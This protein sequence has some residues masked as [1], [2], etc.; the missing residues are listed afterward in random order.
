MAITTTSAVDDDKSHLFIDTNQ[1]F[2]TTTT[3]QSIIDDRNEFN[4]LNTQNNDDDGNNSSTSTSSTAL[5]LSRAIWLAFQKENISLDNNDSQM[6]ANE[7]AKTFFEK[8]ANNLINQTIINNQTLSTTK[9]TTTTTT[10]GGEIFQFPILQQQPPSPISSHED[11]YRHLITIIAYSLII[12]ISLCGNS[13]VLK[14]ILTK[15]KLQTTTNILIAWLAVA[16]L[17]T[18]TLNIPFNVTRFIYMN[19][20]FPSLFCKL[21]PFIQVMCVYVST[22]TMGVIAVHRYMTVTSAISKSSSSSTS[23]ST[24]FRSSMGNTG[25][26]IGNHSSNTIFY[27]PLILHGSFCLCIIMTIVWLLAGLLATPHSMFNQI[28]YVPYQ[29]RTYI[30]CRAE[31]PQVDF[32]LRLTLSVEAFLTQ[33]LIPLGLICVLY[34]KIGLV[35]AK[36]GR[37][38]QKANS[39]RRMEQD[40]A[41]RRRLAMLILIVA[42]FGICWMPL[43]LYHLLV[44]FHL[45]IANFNIFL[46]CHWIAMSSVCWN[47][48]IYCW[49]NESFRKGAT[50][51]IIFICCCCCPRIRRQFL[52]KR[53]TSEFIPIGG[54]GVG[55]RSV[56]AGAGGGTIS[57]GCVVTIGIASTTSSSTP[58]NTLTTAMATTTTTTTKNQQQKNKQNQNQK[59]DQTTTTM[60]DQDNSGNV[61]NSSYDNDNHPDISGCRSSSSCINNNNDHNNNRMKKTHRRKFHKLRSISLR[62]KNITKS[63]ATTT[64]TTAAIMSDNIITSCKHDDNDKKENDVKNQCIKQSQQHQLSTLQQQQQQDINNVQKQQTKSFIVNNNN[65]DDEEIIDNNSSGNENNSVIIIS[66]NQIVPASK[67]STT[68]IKTTYV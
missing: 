28:V 31:Y 36:Q 63:I 17:L 59:N 51:M 8:I 65:C 14:M 54:S 35:V 68:T 25:G 26:G 62:N 42:M 40:S 7:V 55:V 18:T 41:R 19:Y 43:N 22:F 5:L 47:P 61:N 46:I 2:F 16:D 11:F 29:N 57:G 49:L 20:P 39:Q 44:D 10:T 12:L 37:I 15:K 1:M 67:T 64:T 58:I 21:V 66:T 53:R 52:M 9:S 32:N 13:L 56:G 3:I 24:H 27:H 30:R 45:I 33:Y 60:I 4:I 38:A 23:T 6:I 50:K 48:F 34:I